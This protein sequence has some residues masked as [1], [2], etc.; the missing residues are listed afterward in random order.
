MTGPPTLPPAC[1]VAFKE[2][3]G[4]CDALARGRQSLILRKGGI[5][6]GP[7]GFR[8]EHAIFWL[9]PTHLHE[10]QQGLKPQPPARD[11]WTGPAGRVPLQ[12]LA[13][14]E[15]LAFVDDPAVLPA[16][17]PLHVWTPQTV[18]TRF[19]YRQPGLWVLSVR[20]YRRERP[21]LWR[22]TDAQLGCKTWVPLAPAVTTDGLA[23]VLDEPEAARRRAALSAA[24]RHFGVR[25][26]TP[27]PDSDVGSETP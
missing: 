21:E 27:P 17:D 10:A 12:T 4:V 5:A 3:A 22:V 20:V 13:L 24:L 18:A 25:E 9:Y 14:T 7:G 6:E 19:H 26:L 11:P 8:P 2:W 23:T 16:L 15:S 1:G